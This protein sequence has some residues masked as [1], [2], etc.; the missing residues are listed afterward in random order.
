MAAVR[1]R[2][3]QRFTAPLLAVE[4]AF[5]DPDLL[6]HLADVPH[7]GR[8]QLLD[9]SVEDGTVRQQV[10]YRFEGELSAAVTSVIDPDRLTWVEDSTLERA[11]HRTDFVILPDHYPDRLRCQGVVELDEDGAGTIR[12][13]T[14]ADLKVRALLV[15]SRVERA[16]ASGL[17]DHAAA[18]A[19]AVQAWLDGGG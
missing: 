10:R 2:L 6:A 16:I 18:Q 17:R 9:R 12:R 15:A 19:A 14:E 3:E 1:F 8:P 11:T 4:E 5:V 7:L 13:V